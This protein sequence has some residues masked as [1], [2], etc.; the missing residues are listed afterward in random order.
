MKTR[1]T[2]TADVYVTGGGTLYEFNLLTEKARAWAREN[3]NAGD[4]NPSFPNTIFVEHRYARDLAAAFTEEGF[5][6]K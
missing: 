6:V 5:T 4:F 1:S 2:K 3:V